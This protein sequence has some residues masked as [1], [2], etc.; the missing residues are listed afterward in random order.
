VVKALED[1]L[2]GF[3]EGFSEDTVRFSCRAACRAVRA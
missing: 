2:G 3:A 1:H